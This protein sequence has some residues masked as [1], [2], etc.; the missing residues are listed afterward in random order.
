MKSIA[1]ARRV[2]LLLIILLTLPQCVAGLLASSTNAAAAAQANP[3]ASKP[4]IVLQAGSPCP[5]LKSTS[6]LTGGCWLRWA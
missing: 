6:A 5:S 1:R 2:S 4:E 3:A